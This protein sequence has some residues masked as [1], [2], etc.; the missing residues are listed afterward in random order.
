MTVV[1]RKAMLKAVKQFADNVWRREKKK[2][3]D[4]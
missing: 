2:N 3:S 1:Q 4:F